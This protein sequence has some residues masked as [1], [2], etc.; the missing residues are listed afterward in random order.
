[1]Q[2]AGI[3]SQVRMGSTRLPS[4]VLLP[5]AGRPLLDYHVTRL[6]QSGLPVILATT[7]EPADDVLAAYAEA[8]Q[9]P[10]HRGSEADVLARYYETAQKFDLDV[11]V[12]VT[13][14][15]PL[16]DGPLIGAA[17]ARYL[18]EGNPLVYRSNSIVRTFPRGLDF[19]IFSMELLAEAYANAT[20]P[21]EREHVTPYIKAKPATAGRVIYRDE[22]WPGG[23]LS[24]FR[25]TLDTAEDY[26]VLR[27]LIEQYGAAELRVA[28]LLALLEAHPEIM[29]LNA[30]IEQKT[31]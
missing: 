5:A 14:D 22:V 9:L 28:D 31:T 16:V 24:R 27:A 25:I 23:D 2:R 10:Y 29:A 1:M 18:E 21:Y 20:L 6:C 12:R 8:N 4:K 26:E 13:S 15:C 11:I 19:E 7:T 17:V 30:H 3:I